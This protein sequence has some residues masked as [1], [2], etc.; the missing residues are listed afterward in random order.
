MGENAMNR[1]DFLKLIG[2]GAGAAA[3][4]ASF[5]SVTQALADPNLPVPLRVPADA[6]S[7][8]PVW[9]VLNRVTFGPRPGQVDAVKKMGLQTYLDQQLNPAAIDDSAVED[10]LGNYMSLDLTVPEL[11]NVESQGAEVVYELDSATIIRAVHSQRELYQVMVNFWSEH[12]SMYHGK[13]DCRFLITADDRDVIRQN[14]MGKFRD[15]LF[16]SAK[17]PA[18]LVFLDNYKSDKKHPNENYARELMELH[19]LGVGN[20]TEK[21][22]Q[23]LARC[24]TGWTLDTRRTSD[25]VGKF[26]FKPQMHDDGSKTVLGTTLPAGGGIKDAETVLEMLVTSP[27]T[28]LRIATKLCRRF[29]QDTPPAS[30]VNAVQQT[31]LQ[32]D[33]DIPSMLRTIFASQEFLNAPPKY[34]RSY[35]FVVSLFRALNADVQPIG[36]TDARGKTSNNIGLAPLAILRTLEQLPFNHQTPEGYSDFGASWQ[37]NLLIRWN[38]AIATV[39]GAVPGVLVNVKDLVVQQKV[40]LTDPHNILG[41]FAAQFLGR[42]LTSQEL[43]PLRAYL[44]QKGTPTLTTNEGRSLTGDAIAMLACAPAAMFR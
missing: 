14:A 44:S 34:K 17:S 15:L 29:I 22:V 20:Y 21:D 11:A 35:E 1:R 12:F 2:A 40:D 19:T 30:I 16:P 38:T 27:A 39:Y 6:D 4:A 37:S 36:G 13:E 18:M 3:F 8:D 10:K 42:P 25:Q 33:G 41:Y 32:T 23:E 5:D 24:L 43:D 28:A 9:H 7:R 31:Y 26:L